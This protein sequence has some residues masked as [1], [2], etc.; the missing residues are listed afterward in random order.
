MTTSMRP[1]RT[2]GQARPDESRHVNY[3]LGM[4]L[5]VDDFTQEYA[6]LSGHDRWLAREAIGYGT[7]SGLQVRIATGQQGTEVS[8][9]PG[10]ALTPR[11]EIVRICDEQCALSPPGSKAISPNCARTPPVGSG[12][13][14]STTFMP[15]SCS[16]T[17][18]ARESRC[19]FRASRVVAKTRP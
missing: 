13:R 18:N 14:S 16:A 5:G 11:G 15:G 7:V 6:Y 4:V 1:V 17:A 9:S 10:V 19:R 3:T 2:D 12:Y 8:V